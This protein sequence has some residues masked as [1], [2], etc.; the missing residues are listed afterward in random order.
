MLKVPNVLGVAR[1]SHHHGTEA[2]IFD[3]K[4]LS[5]MATHYLSNYNGTLRSVCEVETN[6]IANGMTAFAG[7]QGLLGGATPRRTEDELRDRWTITTEGKNARYGPPADLYF[8]FGWAGLFLGSIFFGLVV[9]SFSAL[10]Q[11]ALALPTASGGILAV[12]TSFNANFLILGNL[13]GIPPHFVY[14]SLPFYVVFFFMNRI[15]C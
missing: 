11:H 8:N 3:T 5:R 6:G 1:G 12:F 4:K 13:S 9:C 14:Y 7:I 10:Y 15:K 2:R